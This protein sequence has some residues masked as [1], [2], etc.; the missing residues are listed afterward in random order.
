MKMPNIPPN[1]S[2][3]H[4]TYYVGSFPFGAMPEST[5]QLPASGA[6]K[7]FSILTT[8]KVGLEA[9]NLKVIRICI[10]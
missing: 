5:D 2:N 1:P 8:E 6:R 10:S 7:H 9:I 4:S 3:R